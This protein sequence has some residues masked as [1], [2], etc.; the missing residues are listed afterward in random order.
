[1][2]ALHSTTQVEDKRL[3]IDVA[4]IKD[5]MTQNEIN[6][7]WCRGKTMLADCLT[8]TGCASDNLL[9]VVTTGSL[10]GHYVVS[11]K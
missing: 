8:K 9:Q 1:M 11:G 6:V 2:T 5:C 4:Y 10:E 7:F 3:R